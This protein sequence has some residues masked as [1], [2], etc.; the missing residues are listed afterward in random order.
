M[1]AASPDRL[2]TETCS[3]PLATGKLDHHDA[4]FILGVCFLRVP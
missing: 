2:Q 4:K 1:F 3:T